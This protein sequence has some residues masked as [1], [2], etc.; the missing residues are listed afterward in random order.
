MKF[1][2]EQALAYQLGLIECCLAIIDARAEQVGHAE[3][4]AEVVSQMRCHA[5]RGGFDICGA[6]VVVR[7]RNGTDTL[8]V[9]PAGESAWHLGLGRSAEEAATGKVLSSLKHNPEFERK[10]VA[11]VLANRNR[12]GK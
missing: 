5:N 3:A 4:E 7:T 1:N 2:K 12:L 9:G 8:V 10:I 11:T 6:N